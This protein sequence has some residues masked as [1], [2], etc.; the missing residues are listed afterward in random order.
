MNSFDLASAG[1]RKARLRAIADA[2]EAKLIEIDYP[3]RQ[4]LIDF[5]AAEKEISPRLHG[6]WRTGATR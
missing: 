5:I 1:T 6:W 2:L 3:V 4:A